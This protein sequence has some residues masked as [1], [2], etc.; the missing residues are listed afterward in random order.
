MQEE[1]TEFNE[2]YSKQSANRNEQSSEVGTDVNELDTIDG[3]NRESLT[4]WEKEP[5]LAVLRAHLEFARQETNDQATNVDGW[6]DLRNATG[7]EAPKKAKPGRSAIQP[8][9]VRKHNEWRYPALS[10]PFLNTDR[11][12]EVLPRTHEDTAKA[13]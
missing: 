9:L 7:K 6:L 2:E 4:E 8:K 13:R 3:N 11:M 1:L 5:T 10:E 12:F